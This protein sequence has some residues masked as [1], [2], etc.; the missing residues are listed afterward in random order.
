MGG[1]HYT[2]FEDGD[3]R[4]DNRQTK[5]EFKMIFMEAE[6]CVEKHHT[7]LVIWKQEGKCGLTGRKTEEKNPMRSKKKASTQ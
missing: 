5:T 6:P 1:Q 7:S 4:D 2:V 3:T